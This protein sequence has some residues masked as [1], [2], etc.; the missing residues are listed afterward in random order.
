M[1]RPLNSQIVSHNATIKE[2]AN[3]K[4][5]RKKTADY[6]D[7]WLLVL[8]CPAK[9]HEKLSQLITQTHKTQ[10]NTQDKQNSR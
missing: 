4:W 2:Q 10:I 9:L 6:D 8:K 3:D 1:F 7:T 5:E